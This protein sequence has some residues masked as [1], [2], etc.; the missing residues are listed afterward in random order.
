[1]GDTRYAAEFLAN[2]ER[3]RK[4]RISEVESAATALEKA[5]DRYEKA[6]LEAHR[7]GVTNTSIAIAAKR[8]EAAIRAFIKRKKMIG[9]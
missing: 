8:T 4:E 3:T 9:R 2:I 5:W 7:D 6:V 1:M